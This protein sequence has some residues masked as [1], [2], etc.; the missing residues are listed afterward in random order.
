[1][2][3]LMM[4]N[5]KGINPRLPGEYKTPQEA[6]GKIKD[7]IEAQLKIGARYVYH[8]V[9]NSIA[10]FSNTDDFVEIWREYE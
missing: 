8:R 7:I 9:A 5:R 6:N 2:Y 4:T 3:Y 1:M 10:I